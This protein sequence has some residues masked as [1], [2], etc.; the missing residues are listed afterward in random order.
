MIGMGRE[1]TRTPA[2]AHIEPKSLPSP[3]VGAMSP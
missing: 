2:T 1:R 3:V